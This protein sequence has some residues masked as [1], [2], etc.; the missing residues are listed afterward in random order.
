MV[1][2]LYRARGGLYTLTLVPRPCNGLE[3]QNGEHITVS[4]KREA[5]AICKVRGAKPYNW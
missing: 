4:G 3:F 5:N 1:A 2:Y